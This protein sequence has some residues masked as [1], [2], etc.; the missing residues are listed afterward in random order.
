[1]APVTTSPP[2]TRRVSTLELFFDLVFVFT[3]TQLTE[4]LT[5]ESLGRG[6]A[7]VALMLSIVFWMYGGYAWLTNAV[8]LDRRSRRAGL[9]AGMGAYLALALAI[10]RAFDDAGLVFGLAYLVVVCV[11]SALFRQTRSEGSR[12]GIAA[13]APFNLA[14][15][16][17]VVAGGAIGGNAQYALWAVAVIGMWLTPKLRGHGSFEIAPA[18]FVERHGLVVIVAIGESIVAIGIGAEGL[19]VDAALIGV[20]LL[21]LA[22]SALL[23]WTYFGGDDERAEI[24]LEDAAP[25]DRPRIALEGFGYCHLAL[26]LGVI[27]VSAGLKAVVA[28]PGDELETASALHLAG[29]AALF[30]LADGAFQ[31]TLSIGDGR[32]RTLAGLALLITLPLGLAVSA[33]AML[34]ALVALYAA[35]LAVETRAVRP[36]GGRARH[37]G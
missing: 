30:L 31:R 34:V 21:G 18:H 29:G 2:A 13:I 14:T 25:G 36:A 1:M 28:H 11:H 15:A 12:R 24:A 5:H 33:T 6:L 26:L 17:L 37:G 22:L 8:E 4:V 27:A 23:W 32:W 20:A 7:Q 35:A 10:P 3:A 9:L 19:E 16:A